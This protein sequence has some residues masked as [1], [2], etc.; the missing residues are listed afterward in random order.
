[1]PAE[2]KSAARPRHCLAS[3]AEGGRQERKKSEHEATAWND[4]PMNPPTVRSALE[5]AMT[6]F[7]V[8]AIA[9]GLLLA[10]SGSGLAAKR[11]SDTKG[12]VKSQSRATSTRGPAI[13]PYGNPHPYGRDYDPYAPGVNWPKYD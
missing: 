12:A 4:G 11:T 6:R 2:M 10:V 7:H 3:M 13:R 1:M 9:S 8:V 5:G